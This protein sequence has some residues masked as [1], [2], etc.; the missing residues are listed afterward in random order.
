MDDDGSPPPTADHGTTLV[1]GT[2]ERPPTNAEAARADALVVL[3][4]RDHEDWLDAV[5]SDP[6]G[7]PDALV[8]AGEMLR[9]AAATV[10]TE[11][12]AGPTVVDVPSATDLGRIAVSVADAVEDLHATADHVTVVIDGVDVVLTDAGVE[13]GFRLLHVLRG[14]TRQTA[15][16]L[17]AYLDPTR[18]EDETRRILDPLF[19]RVIDAAI[20]ADRRES[21][22]G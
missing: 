18:I 2:D 8:C 10:A 16:D 7:G 20:S 6:S 11:G 15:D 14:H 17:T 13:R 4:F 1:V 3:A 21:I 5:Y 12:D 22:R 19:D 9:S